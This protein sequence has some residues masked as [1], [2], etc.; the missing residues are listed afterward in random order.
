[1]CYNFD[2]SEKKESRMPKKPSIVKTTTALPGDA[3]SSNAKICEQCGTHNS[4]KRVKCEECGHRLP[5][6]KFERSRRMREQALRRERQVA[7]NS[8]LFRDRPLIPDDDTAEGVLQGKKRTGA[9][10]DIDASPR[11]ANAKDDD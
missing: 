4:F 9:G 2:V 3:N 8:T 11:T 7:L 1:M 10:T 6:G 5:D